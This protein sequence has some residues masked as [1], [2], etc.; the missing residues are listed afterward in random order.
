MKI[1]ILSVLVLVSACSSQPT[2]TTQYLLRSASQQ[3]SR[4]LNPS[5]DYRFASL[6]VADYIDQ[7]GLVL[8][9]GAGEIHAAR[10]HQWAEPLRTSLKS[11]LATEV[12]REVG[13]D[14]FFTGS[15]TNPTEIAIVI[16]QL[17]GNSR[18]EAVLVAYWYLNRAQGDDSAFQFAETQ[19]L[20]RDGYGAL[21]DAELILLRGLALQIAESLVK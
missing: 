12:S 7:S 8:E 17:H 14:I 4:Q 13:E 1:L 5:A 21:V 20:A 10:N 15:G 2:S 19:A 9:T 3:Q 18:G 16:D 11:Y 6:K